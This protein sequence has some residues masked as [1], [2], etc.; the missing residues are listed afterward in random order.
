ME[1]QDIGGKTRLE[2]ES[3]AANCGGGAFVA[4]SYCTDGFVMAEVAVKTGRLIIT[5]SSE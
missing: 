4:K 5:I 2:I 3:I 1:R